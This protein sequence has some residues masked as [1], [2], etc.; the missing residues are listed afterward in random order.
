MENA[1]IIRKVKR[2]EIYLYDFGTNPESVQ[3]G[4]RP[5]LVVQCDDENEASTTT[6]VAAM[7]TAIKKRYVP[8]HIVLGDNFGWKELSMVMLEQIRT[9]N[10]SSL[11][12][13]IGCVNSEYMQKQ[14]NIG[15]KKAFGLWVD[16][17]PKRKNDLRCLCGKCLN[18]Y[19]S[20]P[21]YIV[22]RL[23][24]FERNKHQCNKCSGSGYYYII[25]T[26]KRCRGSSYG[27]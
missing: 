21:D 16:T 7:T 20:N 24:P 9:V 1:N 19:K 2:G 15:L 4:I 14:I 10:Q 23:D 8:S 5:V 6:V 17:P 11:L 18:D 25:Y 13:Y 3:D 12:T 22:R 26:K 27:N